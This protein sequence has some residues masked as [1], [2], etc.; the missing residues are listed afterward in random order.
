MKDLKELSPKQIYSR[1]GGSYLA[2]YLVY[3]LL[4]T[5]IIFIIKK[6][7]IKNRTGAVKSGRFPF[8]TAPVLFYAVTRWDLINQPTVVYMKYL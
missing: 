2:G 7:G 8:F 3:A 6:A 5:A 1:F 4:S